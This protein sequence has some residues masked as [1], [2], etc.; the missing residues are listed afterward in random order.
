MHALLHKRPPQLGAVIS[1]VKHA[2]PAVPLLSP[3]Q[4]PRHFLVQNNRTVHCEE[5]VVAFV[6]N[7]NL[8]I[9]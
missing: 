5:R 6:Y 7:I 4:N 9:S 8:N 3:Q 1:H 2:M